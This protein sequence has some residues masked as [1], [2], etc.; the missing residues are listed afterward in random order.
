[1]ARARPD[2]HADVGGVAQEGL[3]PTPA[4]RAF[5]I[6]RPPGVF[7]LM[8]AINLFNY[9]D[10]MIA[11]AVGPALKVEFQLNARAIGILSSAFV[12][13][14]TVS[15]LPL[16]ALADR[17]RSRARVVAL[18]VGFWSVF[19]GLTALARSFG[20]LVV[21]RALVGVGEASYYPAGAA[22]L[23]DYYPRA[24]RAR[25]MGRWQTGQMV[26]ILLA[27]GLSGALFALLPAH[28]AWRVAFLVSAIPGLALAALMWLVADPRRAPVSSALDSSASPPSARQQARALIGQISAAL[29]IPTIWVVVALQAIIFIISTPAITFLP[30]YVSA[31]EGPFHLSPAHAAFLTGIIVVVGGVL[32]ALLGG[33]L[34]D[35]LTRRSGGG[36]VLAVGVGFLLALPCFAAM[37]LTTH[38]PVFALAGLLAVLALYLP[39]GPLTAIT[40]D[41]APPSLRAT[42]V[43]VTMLLSHILGDI[44]A[45]T[46]VGALS[47][48][49]NERIGP[50]LL[51]VGAPALI[52]GC[53]IA[54]VGARLYASNLR[55]MPEE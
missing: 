15:A 48:A 11:V 21:T 49:L 25:I 27:F 10:R 17:A 4:R 34:A 54:I 16:G 23:S 55:D 30:I 51:M 6:S 8:F 5:V 44:W 53:A 38:L 28:I 24:A 41:V 39:T 9:L 37:L 3:T 47:T 42:A 14:Y 46:A 32:G 26:G 43:A 40:Q 29:R 1:M 35:L 13:I 33:P 12:L 7:W 20:S 2:E 50:A 45:P 22:L 31:N 52:A 18:G 36:R 19:S